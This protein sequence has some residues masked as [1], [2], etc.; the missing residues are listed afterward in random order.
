MKISLFLAG[1]ILL[2]AGCEQQVN[3]PVTPTSTVQ[4]EQK[5]EAAEEE[6]FDTNDY[7]DEA[8]GELEAVDD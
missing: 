6:D 4:E 2:G 1:L 7:L 3:I 8:M 5:Q